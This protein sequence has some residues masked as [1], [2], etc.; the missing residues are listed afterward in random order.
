MSEIIKQSNEIIKQSTEITVTNPMTGE[1]FQPQYNDVLFA[2]LQ[3]NPDVWYKSTSFDGQGRLI[4]TEELL[5]KKVYF[6]ACELIDY[7]AI[8]KKTE[9]KESYHYSAFWGVLEETGEAII[10]RAGTKLT[11]L[12]EYLLDPQ[13]ADKLA[14]VNAKGAHFYFPAKL[15]TLPNGNTYCDPALIP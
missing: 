15:K 2:A 9:K 1:I 14:A 7:E 3:E 11:R 5:G 4:D 6:F 10:Y 8:D 12:A 13:N